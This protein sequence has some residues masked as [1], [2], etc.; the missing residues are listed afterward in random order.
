MSSVNQKEIKIGHVNPNR[1]ESLTMR[2]LEVL[3]WKQGMSFE[4]VCNLVPQEA[5]RAGVYLALWRLRRYGLV[6]RDGGFYYLNPL[7][8]DKVE[9]LLFRPMRSSPSS[10]P[11]PPSEPQSQP[12]TDGERSSTI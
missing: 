7:S 8:L 2:A 10:P 11:P 6:L 12:K 9:R 1:F 5:Q 4:N 3:H